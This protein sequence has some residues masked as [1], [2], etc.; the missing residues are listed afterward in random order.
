MKSL[1]LASILSSAAVAYA[2]PVLAGPIHFQPT[3]PYS[4]HGMLLV[5]SGAGPSTVTMGVVPLDFVMTDILLGQP[6]GGGSLPAGVFVTV[7]GN[8]IFNCGVDSYGNTSRSEHLTSG[9]PI[10][11]GSTVAVRG[12]TGSSNSNPITLVGYVQ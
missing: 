3:K 9:V 5:S 11:A 1:V 6:T 4:M 10:P 2:V 7:N 12:Y 8:P